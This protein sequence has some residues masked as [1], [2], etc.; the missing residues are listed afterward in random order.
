LQLSRD[1]S[2]RVTE[3]EER[4]RREKK[5]TFVLEPKILLL[6]SSSTVLRLLYIPCINMARLFP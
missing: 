4:K 6:P 5:M 2:T 1:D 3:L